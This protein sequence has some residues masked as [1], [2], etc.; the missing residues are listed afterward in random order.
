[1]T[2]LVRFERTVVVFMDLEL[3]VRMVCGREL[4]KGVASVV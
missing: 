3:G 2:V 1:M 4:Y